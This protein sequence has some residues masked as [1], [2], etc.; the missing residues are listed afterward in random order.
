[1]TTFLKIFAL[2]TECLE[3]LKLPVL[4]SEGVQLLSQHVLG[5]PPPP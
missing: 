1:M 4:F 3:V 2:E 5:N